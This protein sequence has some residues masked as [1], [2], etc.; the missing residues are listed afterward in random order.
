MDI[1]DC[2]LGTRV[3]CINPDYDNVIPV[4]AVGTIIENGSTIP[5]VSF[6]NVYS[7]EQQEV[8]GYKNCKVM[9]LDEIEV[10]E[11]NTS[12]EGSTI[13]TN[14]GKLSVSLATE[15]VNEIA[16]D[17][18]KVVLQELYVG[19]EALSASLTKDLDEG[20]VSG[21][22]TPKE[23][24]VTEQDVLNN[25][26]NQINCAIDMGDEETA[27]KLSEAY[28]RIKSVSINNN[29]YLGEIL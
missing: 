4:G 3:I 10:L 16:K 27:L 5:W 13:E 21:D 15:D 29:Q 28:Q 22:V 9:G 24:L 12:E 18:L 26:L 8:C 11:E 14:I 6:D 23:S 25:L 1:K 17:I 7:A 19:I 2:E 20:G